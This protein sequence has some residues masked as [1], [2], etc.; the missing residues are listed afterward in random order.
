MSISSIIGLTDIYV[1]PKQMKS[2]IHT[3]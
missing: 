1:W 2:A 3:F